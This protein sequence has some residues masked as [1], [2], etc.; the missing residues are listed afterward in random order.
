[1]SVNKI[2]Y[3]NTTLIDLTGDTVTA[4]DVASGKT[5]H[6]KDGAQTTGTFTPTSITPSSSA[7]AMTANNVYQPTTDGFAID[8]YNPDAVIPS[9]NGTYFPSGFNKM[10]TSGYAYDNPVYTAIGTFQGSTSVRRKITLGFKPKYL[11]I[12]PATTSESYR[13]AY[14]YNQDISTTQYFLALGTGTSWDNLNSETNNRLGRI[15]S[16]GFTM[17]IMGANVALNTWRYFAKG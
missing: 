4:S 3:G 9:A 6:G 5:F 12:M 14:I 1:M 10:T 7:P 15:D 13:Y 2:I 16:D 8:A 17:N 11:A